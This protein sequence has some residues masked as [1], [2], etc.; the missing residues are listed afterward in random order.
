MDSNKKSQHFEIPLRQN[1]TRGADTLSFL[2][3]LLS[4]LAFLYVAVSE[5]KVIVIVCLSIMILLT[6][7]WLFMVYT[8][9]A[10]FRYGYVILLLIAVYWVLQGGTGIFMGLL[11]VTAAALETRLRQVPVINITTDGINIKNVIAKKYYWNNLANVILK[12]GLITIDSKNN[13]LFQKEA[14]VDITEQYEA[15]IN[16]FCRLQ[17]KGSIQ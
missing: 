10:H 4:L 13:K 17:L 2:M 8:H 16:E 6:V 14:R 15:E 3:V 7:R 9:K 12:D 11:F 5:N 1:N